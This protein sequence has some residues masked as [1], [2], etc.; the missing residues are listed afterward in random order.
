MVSER[1][2][3]TAEP[4]FVEP[5]GTRTCEA[6]RLVNQFW[7]WKEVHNPP[8]QIDSNGMSVSIDEA[9]LREIVQGVVRETLEVF[10]GDERLAFDE[11]DAAKLLGVP[12]HT[13]R[14][15]RL[16]GEITAKK[17]G[18]SWRYSRRTLIRFLENDPSEN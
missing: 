7:R 15:C 9:T 2:T 11:K 14:D 12:R 1:S 13:L 17:I 8:M 16:R 3:F 5:I 10:A 4:T 6:R 18:K